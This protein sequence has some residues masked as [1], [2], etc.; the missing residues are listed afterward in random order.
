VSLEADFVVLS[1]RGRRGNYFVPHVFSLVD[2]LIEY[3][4]MWGGVITT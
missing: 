1:I 2:L 4:R 3:R